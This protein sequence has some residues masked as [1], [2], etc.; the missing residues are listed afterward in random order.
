[1][2]CEI[3]FWPLSSSTFFI[4]SH[5]PT[6][7]MTAHCCFVSSVVTIDALE[8]HKHNKD[9]TSDSY[10]EFPYGKLPRVD[11]IECAPIHFWFYYDM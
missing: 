2:S 7:G 8:Q 3:T 4:I 10:E 6:I 11:L 9:S 1:M 5:Q